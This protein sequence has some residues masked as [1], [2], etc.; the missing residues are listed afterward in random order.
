MLPIGPQL[1]TLF[2]NPNFIRVLDDEDSSIRARF[3]GDTMLNLVNNKH[4]FDNRYDIGLSLYVDRFQSHKKGGAKLNL[5]MLQILNLPSAYR[6]KIEFL[7]DFDIIPNT[8]RLD[9]YLQYLVSELEKL[10]HDG[11]QVQRN[12]STSI[13]LKV[14]LMG[15]FGDIPSVSE[16]NFLAS[17]T[18]LQGCRF[19]TIIG[20]SKNEYKSSALELGIE[21]PS[22]FRNLPSFIDPTFVGLDEFH[23]FGQNMGPRIKKMFTDKESI[24]RLK[25]RQIE[26]IIVCLNQLASTS[27]LIIF[28]GDFMDVFSKGGTARGVDWLVFLKYFVPTVEYI[29]YDLHSDSSSSYQI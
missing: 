25:P 17:H 6:Y 7:I 29:H 24:L 11:L 14:H 5:V 16:L 2:E 8:K 9:S 3:K 26:K 27:P 28:E 18:S 4:L 10:A 22:L 23:L 21:R 12:N 13:S 15:S 20:I 19:C 1:A